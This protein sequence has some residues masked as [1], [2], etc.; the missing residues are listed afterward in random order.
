[1]PIE[2]PSLQ[3]VVRESNFYLE[4]NTQTFESPVNRATQ[5]KEQAGARWRLDLTLRAMHRR[6]AAAWIAFLTRMRGRV[7]SCYV[8]DPDYAEPLGAGGGT[9]VVDGGGQ[10]G[11]SLQVKDCAASQ[12]QWLCAGDYF[13]AGGELKRL[14]QDANTNGSGQVTLQF[15]SFFRNSPGDESPVTII[16]PRAL[17][18]LID[19]NQLS[20]PSN[21]RRIYGEKTISFVEKLT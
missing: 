13:E 14:T 19:D 6:E 7:E 5:T 1:M 10:T 4:T 2:M 8:Y 3:G 12:F 11:T 20:W 18:C 17:M 9:P 15:E 21:A 16:R